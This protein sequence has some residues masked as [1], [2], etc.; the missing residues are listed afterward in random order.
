MG[1]GRVEAFTDG[2]VAIIITIMVLELKVPHGEDF[3]A[4]LPLWPIFFSYVLSFIN[5]GIYWNN[6]HNMFHTVQRVDGRVLWANLNLLFWL[7]LMPATT[8][9]M[10]ENH[11]APV[12]VA[13]Y[14]IDLVL[15]A[16]AYTFLA[17]KLHHLHGNDTAFAK[18]LGNDRKGKISVALYA[19]AVPLAF[20]NQWIG[21]AIFVLVAAVWFVPDTRFSRVL[22]K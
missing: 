17:T 19:A 18:A 4:L 16:V 10:G 9:F 3:S 13:V 8:A 7:S 14:G 6:L 12:P 1:K 20:V 21:V 2:V 11:F 5:V 22:E 15:C